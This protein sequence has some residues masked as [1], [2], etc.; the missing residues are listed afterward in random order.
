[1]ESQKLPD[2]GENKLLVA[3]DDINTTNADERKTELL[4][5]HDCVVSILY[6]LKFVLRVEVDLSPVDAA[7]LD[8]VHDLEQNNAVAK[9]LKQVVDIKVLD[10]EGIDPHAKDSLGREERNA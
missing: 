10:A 6:L 3:I 2:D 4:A 5:D 7:R 9:V 8:V 1:M